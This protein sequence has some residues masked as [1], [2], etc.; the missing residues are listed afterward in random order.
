MVELADGT[1][2]SDLIAHL[3]LAKERIGVV[4][5]NG[6]VAK[7]DTRLIADALVNLYQPISGG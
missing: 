1:C 5:M 2:I 3:D 4:S 6:K 7:A